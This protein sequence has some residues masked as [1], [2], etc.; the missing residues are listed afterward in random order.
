MDTACLEGPPAALAMDFDVNAAAG[1]QRRA[2]AARAASGRRRRIDPTTCDREYTAAE[3]EFMRA[4]D[5]YK[6]G[7]GRMFPTWSEVLEVLQ[8]LGYAKAEA[9]S[10]AWAH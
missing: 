9:P 4:M 1:R 3:L 5:A 7:S 2:N 6:R 10:P 8:S